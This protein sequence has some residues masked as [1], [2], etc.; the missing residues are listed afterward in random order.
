MAFCYVLMFLVVGLG[1]KSSTA[2]PSNDTEQLRIYTYSNSSAKSFSEHHCIV[3]NDNRPIYVVGTYGM[4]GYFE[5]AFKTN[6]S[7]ALV[8]FYEISPYWS[9]GTPP[10]SPA[11]PSKDTPQPR[12]GFASLAYAE[13]FTSVQGLF[14]GSSPS[15]LLGSFAS[16]SATNGREGDPADRTL[17]RN[18][19]LAKPAN[20][21]Y[22][23]LL[24]APRPTPS[25][26]STTAPAAPAIAFRG[27][28]GEVRLC[29][30]GPR[31]VTGNYTYVYQ[32]DMPA[33]NAT[34]RARE[35][36]ALTPGAIAFTGALPGAAGVAGAWR[37]HSGP[38][39]G[40]ASTGL[41]VARPGAGLLGYT[42]DYSAAAGWPEACLYDEYPTAAPPACGPNPPYPRCAGG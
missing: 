1:L 36:G 16:W 18:C 21:T 41:F 19:L 11:F 17:R 10:S 25:P 13:N 3:F 27:A 39:A 38:R 5:G 34:K 22:R 6:S 30:D 15:D 37:T 31:G 29:P 28:S 4:F 20:I 14:G 32:A 26:R 8:A 33:R 9:H 40:R 2:V 7:T 12:S 23:A 35:A 42:C 24:A